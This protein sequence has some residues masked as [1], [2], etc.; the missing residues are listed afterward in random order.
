MAVSHVRT[1]RRSL[2]AL[3]WVAAVIGFSGAPGL[4]Q[5]AVEGSQA[6]ILARLEQMR[7][8][9][10][11]SGGWPERYGHH[12]CKVFYS[13]RNV[14]DRE[15]AFDSGSFLQDEAYPGA[16]GNT[17]RIGYTHWLQ[18]GATM[19]LENYCVIAREQTQGALHLTGSGHFVGETARDTI[20]W[21][22]SLICPGER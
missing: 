20:S 9:R 19:H 13:L 18:P 17:G 4:S 15:I 6:P 14:A 3:V 2:V 21:N 12:R 1:S 16:G 10:F 5:S 22:L 7:E 11:A 8:C